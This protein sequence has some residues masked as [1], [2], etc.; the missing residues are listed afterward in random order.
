LPARS[1][2]MNKEVGTN[3]LAKDVVDMFFDSYAN[4]F[5]VESWWNEY[6]TNIFDYR[7]YIF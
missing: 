4:V 1:E 6:L 2:D 3:P 7:S 5:M